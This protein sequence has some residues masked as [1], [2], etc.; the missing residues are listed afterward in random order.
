M[1]LEINGKP[2]A[3][4]RVYPAA[5]P[6]GAALATLDTVA[7]VFLLSRAPGWRQVRVLEGAAAGTVGWVQ[8]GGIVSTTDGVLSTMEER[9]E[10]FAALRAA[11]FTPQGGQPLPIPY[12]Y[13]A[14]GCFARAEI[15]AR[16]LADSGYKADKIFAIA[17][18]DNGLRLNTSHGG[19]QPGYGD[20]LQVQWWYHVAPILYEPSATTKPEAVVMDPSVADTPVTVADW[21]GRM[22]TRPSAQEVAYEDLR[23]ELRASH[24]YPTDRTLVVRAGRT[25]YAPPSAADPDTT[26]VAV[27]ADVP[28]ELARTA[29]LVPAHDVVAALDQFFR[30]CF[31]TWTTNETTRNKAVPYPAYPTEFAAVR[32]MILALTPQLRLYIRTRFPKFFQDWRG[33]FVGSGV[34]HDFAV[35]EKL[36]A[37]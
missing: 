19:D 33:T 27:P 25:V 3:P 36:L 31:D 26:V 21:V 15:M 14:D 23:K 32:G 18:G 20:R 37:S 5:N 1:A 22:S 2:T 17:A 24:A 9:D 6:T 11:R 16:M 28:Q 12:R 29:A 13:P 35:L 4:V 7:R 34:E 30:V 8:D 10:L